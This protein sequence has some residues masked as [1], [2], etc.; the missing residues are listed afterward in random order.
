M[1]DENK[2]P[3]FRARF[4]IDVFVDDVSDAHIVR[5]TVFM[6]AKSISSAGPV[7]SFQAYLDERADPKSKDSADSGDPPKA[8]GASPLN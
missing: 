7:V 2:P 3:R 6:L 1:S 8:K 5:E 4:V